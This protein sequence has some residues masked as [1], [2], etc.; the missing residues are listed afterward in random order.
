M[1]SVVGGKLGALVV[2]VG[3]SLFALS[4]IISWSLYGSRCFEYLCGKLGTK[5]SV[6]YKIIFLVL[7]P[8]GATLKIGVV[9]DLAD[10]LNGMMA[11]PNL[12][13]LL[14]L[15]GVIIKSTKEYFKKL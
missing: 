2:A 8:I 11:F 7:L 3:L 10:A 4:T 5:L 13:A 6:I 12:V 15:S 9:W 14:L 1:G